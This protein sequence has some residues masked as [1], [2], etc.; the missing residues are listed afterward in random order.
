MSRKP[1]R[2]RDGVLRFTVRVDHRVDRSALIHIAALQLYGEEDQDRFI[3]Q[4][5]LWT[6]VERILRDKGHDYTWGTDLEPGAYRW[7]SAQVDRLYPAL[8]GWL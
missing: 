3:T 5:E 7:A 6:T 8:R 4:A 2:S 1:V